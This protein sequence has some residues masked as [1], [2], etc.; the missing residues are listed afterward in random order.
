MTS[1]LLVTG[2]GGFIGYHAAVHFREQ[3][4]RVLALDNL[5]RL[6]HLR[7]KTEASYTA[8]W[9]RLADRTGVDRVQADV[10]NRESLRGPVEEADAILHAAGQTAVTAS[11][12]DPG[13]DFNVNTV[14]T[15]NLLEA[16]RGAPGN[17]AFLFCSTNKVYGNWVNQIDVRE[18]DR[19][20]RFDDPGYREGIP[21]NL[22]IDGTKHTPYGC[23]KLAA[24]LYVQEY[25]RTYDLRTG[26]FRMSC[27]Y[28]PHQLGLEDQGWLAWFTLAALLG[29]PITIYGNGKQ[30]RDVLYVSD[31]MELFEAFLGAETSGVWNVGG[32]PV[33]TTSLLDLL[34]MLEDLVGIR[35]DR[36][37]QDWRTGDQKVYV[38]RLSRVRRNLG[39]SPTVGLEDGL[40]RLVEWMKNNQAE[41]ARLV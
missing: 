9:D 37:F 4:Y 34:S 13:N 8:N 41:L 32:G 10:T 14:G 18:E 12:T 28:G 11:L 31:L 3:G 33:H 1:T 29:K 40:E 35:P 19:R 20:Y 25:A 30:V 2:A 22:G 23:S 6:R 27:V 24:D 15:L 17:P 39:W 7:G 16:A 38:S 21:E 36:T 26:V 5:S